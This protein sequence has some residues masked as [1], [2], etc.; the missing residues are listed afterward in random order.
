MI[1]L[2]TAF[3]FTTRLEYERRYSRDNT[4]Y[5]LLHSLL[6]N[7]PLL[8]KTNQIN[9]VQTRWA[10]V[11]SELLW[12]PFSSIIRS[13]LRHLNMCLLKFK[14]IR[15]WVKFTMQDSITDRQSVVRLSVRYQIL[16]GKKEDKRDQKKVVK[17]SSCTLLLAK[18]HDWF[19]YLT[20]KLTWSNL[21]ML[22]V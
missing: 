20:Q 9:G 3:L 10:A 13:A 2:K 19:W 15:Q 7:L 12:P 5:I 6:E 17:N 4:T 11:N 18:T 21:K 8:V 16:N 22:K 14:S 1:F